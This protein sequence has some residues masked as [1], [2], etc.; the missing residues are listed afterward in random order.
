MKAATRV[1]LKMWKVGGVWLCLMP[2][3]GWSQVRAAWVVRYYGVGNATDYAYALAVDSQGNVY[4]TG[5]SY[6]GSDADYVTV[7]YDANGN[8][9]WVARY[10]GPG[11]DTDEAYALALDSQGNVYVTGSSGNYPHS[12]YATV[13]YDAASNLL[14]VAHYNGPGNYYDET[15]ALA[16]D[17]QG[18]VYVTGYSYNSSTNYD[19]ATIKYSQGLTGDVNWDGCVNDQDLSAV[20][21]K[22]GQRCSGCLEDLN[23]DGAVNEDDLSLVLVHYGEGC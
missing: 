9:L 5:Y 7:K 15:R 13:K 4:V 8:L 3:L 6:A 17:S 23:G 22:F 12:D 2:L 18:N 14:W 11:N 10:N 21:L 19:Y 16:L 20:L 1:F